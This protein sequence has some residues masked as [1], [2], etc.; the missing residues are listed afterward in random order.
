M[1]I[2]KHGLLL[3]EYAAKKGANFGAVCTIGRQQ[4]QVRKSDY[5][6]LLNITGNINRLE[7]LNKM[8]SEIYME[9]YENLFKVLF[10]S[11]TTDSIDSNTFEG[12][13]IIH[14]LNLPLPPHISKSKYT[15]VIDF[16]CLEHVF[17][18]AVAFG[19]VINLCGKGGTILH[20][21]PS[22]QMAGH[23]FY[24]FSPEFFFSLYSSK[25]GFDETEVFIFEKSNPYEWFKVPSTIELR[26]RLCYESKGEVYVIVKTTKLK[27]GECTLIK[28]P[29]QQ[30]DYFITWEYGGYG[31]NRE[32]EKNNFT[33]KLKTYIKNH[34][35]LYAIAQK[36][37]S[38]IRT[39]IRK[40]KNPELI[41]NHKDLI[42]ENILDKIKY[43]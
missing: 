26:R 37:N 40:M 39:N 11:T 18:I 22:N 25:R 16:G 8:D 9:F 1:G 12:A 35:I 15:L 31:K 21:L 34:N 19:N 30:S 43:C 3:I 4:I 6:R 42:R 41:S 2:D 33:N 24:Q 13:S 28:D 23:G 17:N 20:V 38:N 36:I 5:K 32:I 10:R 27:W 14:D 29:I 7:K